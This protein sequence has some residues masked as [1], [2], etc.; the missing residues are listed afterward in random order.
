MIGT[1]QN[2]CFCLLANQYYFGSS[3]ETLGSSTVSWVSEW[4]LD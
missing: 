2:V 3:A 4:P 1:Q